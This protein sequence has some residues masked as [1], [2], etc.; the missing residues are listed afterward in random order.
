MAKARIVVE[1]ADRRPYD[2]RIGGGIASE[3]AS[4]LR[5]A[6]I[7]AARCLVI[8]DAEAQGRCLPAL[9]G[10]LKAAG[11]RVS[12]IVL[13]AVEPAHAWECIAEIHRA[14]GALALPAGAPVIV[15]ACVQAAQ[16]AAFAV[17]TYG[18]ELPLVLVPASLASALGTAG[19]DSLEVDAGHPAPLVA[20]ARPALV[21]VD[22]GLLSCGNAE[23]E[24]LGLDDLRLAAAFADADFRDWLA[25]SRDALAAYDGEVL[26][27][28]LAQ[29]IA[30]RADAIGQAI[31]ARLTR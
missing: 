13:P 28:A 15:C 26:A 10:Q 12:D 6:G 20:P 19:V 16:L 3:L 21:V 8:C 27:L 5:G 22:T 4:D 7:D 1:F 17:A 18:A 25:S 29:A 14:L 9:R 2:I 24:S 23:E 11:L 31:A 30:A